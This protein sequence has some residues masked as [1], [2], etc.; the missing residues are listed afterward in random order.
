MPFMFPP[1]IGNLTSAGA[2]IGA[3]TANCQ[4]P[5]HNHFQFPTPTLGFHMSVDHEFL[6]VSAE[7]YATRGYIDFIR[8]PQASCVH[9][10]LLGYIGDSLRWIP[11]LNPSTHQRG[12]GLNFC[13]VTVIDGVGASA[14]ARIFR[15]WAELFRSGR[16][17]LLLTGPWTMVEG[18]TSSGNYADLRFP[19]DEVVT[20]LE[21]IALDCGHAATSSG[22]QFVLHLGI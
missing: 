22:T 13:G 4:R 2:A 12:H 1:R 18:E 19:R 21:R 5:T 17:E 15:N 10:D 8:D 6:L 7:D 11:T 16:E 14:A 9:D 20:A 3:S